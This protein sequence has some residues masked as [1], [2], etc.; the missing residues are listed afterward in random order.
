L[1]QPLKKN[2][3]CLGCHSK[4]KT[5]LLE[6]GER[7]A[8]QIHREDFTGSAHGKIECGSCHQAIANRK[9]PSKK[10]NIT[11]NNQRDYSVE[12][13]ESCRNCHDKKFTQYEGSIHASLV[14][15]GNAIAPVCTDCHSAHA[16]ETMTVYQAV[17]GLPCKNCH[18]DIFDAYA[19]S[20]HGEARKNGNAIRASHIQAPI[21]T[22][23]HRA[24]DVAAVAR[25]DGLRSTCIGCHEGV[26]L[27]HDQWLPNAGLH[28][29]VVSC[30][31]CHAPV[32]ERRIDLQ[33]YDK[34]AK[35][36]VGQ[37]GNNALIWQQ[38]QAIDEKGDSMAP[39]ELWS[40]IGE[41]TQQDQTTDV[42]LRGRMEVASGV[43]AH[44]LANKS[45]A[46]RDCNSCHESGSE[47][48]QN[49]VLSISR[50]DGRTLHYEADQ[51]IL[52]SVVSVDSLGDFYA[53]GG[54]RIKLLDMLLLLSLASGFAI[55]IGHFT[56]GR[57]IRKNEKKGEQ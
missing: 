38:L 30:A 50:L 31:A 54:T 32:V 55:P 22:D 5:K 43:E 15:Q 17:T 2:K 6:D 18:E 44:S 57:I 9:H 56:V 34:V 8:L 47:P 39:L 28:L 26:N 20:V 49:V 16:V 40:L 33:L 45:L 25:D 37:H 29:E 7:M 36:P 52:S 42:T 11:I 4:D 14:G 27:A 23:C 10:T 35:A 24:H 1:R 53:L 12:M 48:F 21:C 19:A 3:K 46:V 51:E 13:N 41:S